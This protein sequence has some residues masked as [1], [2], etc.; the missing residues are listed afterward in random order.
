MNIKSFLYKTLNLKQEESLK[1]TL[2]FFHSFFLGLFI[3]FYFAPANSMF[4]QNFGTEQLPLAYIAAGIAG[5]LITSLYS[6]LQKR[7]ESRS[8]F[9][10]A[11]LFM[12]A[13]PLIARLFLTFIDKSGTI[14]QLPFLNQLGLNYTS[15]QWL[16]FF[17][18]IWGWPFISLVA[19]E[20]GGLV[21]RFLNI[22]QVKRLFGL[23]NIGG[24]I[25]SIIGY[26][27]IPIFMKFISHAY[28]LLVI[29]VG[30]T[31]VS[32]ILL[33]IL[34]KKIPTINKTSEDGSAKNKTDFRGLIKEKYFLLI[35]LSATLSMTVIY[36]SDFG[37]LA[38]IK[39]QQK[40]VS[41]QGEISKFIVLG[42]Y[43]IEVSSFIAFVFGGLKI[44]ELILSY[45][46][47]RILS[48]YGI[49]LGLTILPIISTT[50]IIASTVS[51]FSLGVSSL[52]FF[53]FMVLNKSLERVLRRGL[54]DP[55]FNI[56]YQPLV[57][58]QKLSIQTRVGVIMQLAI[59][60]AGIYLM[61]ATEMLKTESGF[62]L[63]YFSIFFLPVLIAWVFVARELYKSYKV[64]LQEIL[65][66]KNRM[67]AKAIHK[68]IYGSDLLISQ[69]K[70]DD[71]ETVKMGVT[72]LSETNPRTLEPFA[73]SLL[74]SGESTIIK[75]I[76][77][78]IEP[79]WSPKICEV[80]SVIYNDKNN[81]DE[82]KELA[83]QGLN[84]LNYSDL[85][86]IKPENL[87]ELK[88]SE[89]TEDKITL[90]KYFYKKLIKEDV[91]YISKL[92]D[93]SEKIVRQA[94]IK[95]A[96]R[97]NSTVLTK[98]I[99]DLLHKPEF[100]HVS[101]S[102]LIDIGEDIV[103]SLRTLFYETKSKAILI[104]ITEICARIGTPNAQALLISNIN[105]PD[106]EVQL[107]VIKG[108]YYSH[109]SADDKQAIIVKEK[110]KEIVGDILWV[111]LTINDVENEKNT[112]KLIQ[113]LDLERLQKFDVLFYLL[114]F[115]YQPATIDLI[116][117]NIIGE[118]V[119]FAL[120]IIDNFINPDVK[121]FIIP[122]FDK[123][124]VS[125]RARKLKPFFPMTKLGFVERL[126]DIILE[127][128]NRVD[129]WTKTKAIELL[130]KLSRKE[131]NE[132]KQITKSTEE[133]T[134]KIV[135][136]IKINKIEIWTKTRATEVLK[137]IHIEGTHD[138]L[139]LS[140]FH[141]DELV[142]STAAQ[143][144]YATS[145]D[146]CK[147]YLNQMS[148]EKKRLIE[149]LESDKS[150]LVNERVKYI[151]RVPGF[152]GFPENTL[153]KLA[154]LF[155]VK[156]IGRKDVLV[157][158]KENEP[159][160]IFIVVKG[161]LIHKLDIKN[162]LTFSRNDV[163]VRGLNVPQTATEL[164]AKGKT[165]LLIGERFE[166]FNLL[167]DETDIIQYMF[168]TGK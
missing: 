73:I 93:D 34:Y 147:K 22:R 25:A 15:E 119:I 84:S 152:F 75:A 158:T 146:V 168:N 140:L 141:P 139:L 62:N 36:F 107:A 51:G 130:D 31:A 5:Y 108:L 115:I 19:I 101:G 92:L 116:K 162:E 37:F 153:V 100:Y 132:E 72:F 13:L 18:F 17:V 8:L 157:L 52:A 131:N 67:K 96:G 99:I 114:S 29:G 88:Q 21:I 60:L 91:E 122:I 95:L 43:A 163:I 156:N 111:F 113:A 41:T 44:G 148:N 69:L 61:F 9:L 133:Q 137:N 70:N 143:V 63:K 58:E 71:I 59:A 106:I 76:L 1:F 74:S 48:R 38:S 102:T 110:I 103:P 86:D 104:K 112:L 90:I 120:E 145:P 32:I 135:D 138:E 81:T 26:L 78:N 82:I 127:D 85:L 65:E 40:L 53:A 87:K 7:V 129:S 164:A 79:T 3:A 11:L 159:E 16:S 98:K 68:D 109:F 2:L 64:K 150:D 136:N 55:S 166:Y 39:E 28:D 117:T 167:V 27:A 54:D 126:K 45:F 124:S 97:S 56:L 46:S 47:S 134:E 165:L 121:Q 24:V 94:A 35:F 33:V 80:L 105:Y 128:F 123:I 125:Q 77:R 6:Y 49:K 160:K 14:V 50:L 154:K 23:I 149:I 118:N 57:D 12:F 151:R 83:K 42:G 142:Y 144:I 89:K 66:E 155:K 10:S 20:S 4:I 30:G 161:K